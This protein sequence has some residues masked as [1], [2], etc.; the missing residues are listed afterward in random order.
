MSDG[1]L[2]DSTVLQVDE[3]ALTRVAYARLVRKGTHL[4]S[5]AHGPVA[6]YRLRTSLDGG[7]APCHGLSAGWSIDRARYTISPRLSA[8]RGGYTNDTLRATEDEV[9]AGVRLAHAWDLPWF[10]L[11][12]GV[13]LGA[14]LVRQSFATRGVAPTHVTG[15]GRLGSSLTAS[16]DLARGWYASVEVGAETYVF[17][18]QD[19]SGADASASLATPLVGVM[20]V[21]VGARVTLP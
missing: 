21:S 12:V 1:R 13:E 20:L 2:V 16:R 18:E 6:G 8:C 17:E 3:S 5:V 4:A 7:W 14:A 15:A 9:A 10:A 19:G 11:D